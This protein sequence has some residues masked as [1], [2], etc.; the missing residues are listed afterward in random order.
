VSVAL[1]SGEHC[2]CHQRSG[3]NFDNPN[4][5]T[6]TWIEEAQASACE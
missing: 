5:D 4:G 1:E 2:C 3:G 6:M